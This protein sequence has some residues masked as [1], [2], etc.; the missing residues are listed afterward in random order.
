M[1]TVVVRECGDKKIDC[2]YMLDLAESDVRDCT[3]CWTCWLKTPGRCAFKDLDEFYRAYLHADKVIIFSKVTQ[4]FVSGKLKTLFD[5][6]IP[7]YLPYISY[8]SGESMHCPRYEKYP[9]IEV[10]YDGEFDTEDERE[11]YVDYMRRL[12][13]QFLSKCEVV[14]PISEYGCKEGSDVMVK[15]GR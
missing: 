13:Y 14:K 8:K 6:L 2:D 12:C 15:E 7:H 4:G 11:I 5:R 1:K 10:Y 9:D 3:G